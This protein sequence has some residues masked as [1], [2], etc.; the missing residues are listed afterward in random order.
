VIGTAEISRISEICE[1]AL[2]GNMHV[3][4]ISKPAMVY[5]LPA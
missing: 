1:Q 3:M 5:G 4:E 2:L